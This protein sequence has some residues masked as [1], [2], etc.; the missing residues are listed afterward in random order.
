MK[1]FHFANPEAFHRKQDDDVTLSTRLKTWVEY[2]TTAP[3]ASQS[4]MGDAEDLPVQVR[5][6]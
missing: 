3:A 1:G 5:E 6:L 2:L 4:Y